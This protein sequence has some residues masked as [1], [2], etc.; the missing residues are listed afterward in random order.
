MSPRQKQSLRDSISQDILFL[1]QN[2][3]LDE[4]DRYNILCQIKAKYCV[5][6]GKSLKYGWCTCWNEE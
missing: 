4:E 2:D 3:V 5:H 6:C 1:L